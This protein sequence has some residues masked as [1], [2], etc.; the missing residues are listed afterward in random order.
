[1]RHTHLDHRF[2]RELPD[3][4]DPGVLYVSMDYCMAVHS[5]CCGCREEVATP[6]TPTD[7]RMTF[8]GES[9]SLWPSIGNWSLPC[10]SHYVIMRGWVIEAA[11]WTDQQ[12]QWERKRDM[13]AKERYFTRLEQSHG[14]EWPSSTYSARSVVSGI[15]AR[16]SRCLSKMYCCGRCQVA[17]HPF[18]PS[19]DW[20]KRSGC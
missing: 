4:L 7:W 9:I 20:R 3:S 12:I 16:I 14:H 18:R 10:R 1:M 6:F 2:V 19:P 5:C 15:L 8:N 17:W 11:P 13:V